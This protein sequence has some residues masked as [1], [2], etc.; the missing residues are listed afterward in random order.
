MRLTELNV[1]ELEMVALVPGSQS[2][3]IFCAAA[4][5]V[6]AACSARLY[7]SSTDTDLGTRGCSLQYTLILLKA[8]GRGFVISSR[9]P[10]R[11]G[12]RQG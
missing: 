4:R 10:L 12:G 3:I 9:A 1:V 5:V 11:E 2:G 8:R 6:A 7:Y